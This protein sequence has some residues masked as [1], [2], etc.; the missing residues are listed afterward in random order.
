MVEFLTL[1]SSQPA[2]DA[3]SHAGYRSKVM[4]ENINFKKKKLKEN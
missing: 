2:G 3:Y 1:N 4:I